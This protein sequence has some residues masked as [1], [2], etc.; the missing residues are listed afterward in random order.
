MSQPKSPLAQLNLLLLDPAPIALPAG[1]D[2]Q[3][4]QA[5]IELLL[6]AAGAP[7]AAEGENHEP[8]ADR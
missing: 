2:Q 6:N 8:Q 5:L 4:V 1:K 7:V 3:L